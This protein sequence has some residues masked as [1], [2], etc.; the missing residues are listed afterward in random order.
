V[1]YAATGRAGTVTG[2]GMLRST[3][4]GQSWQP[5]GEGIAAL[6]AVWSIAVEPRAPHRVFAVTF[7][8]GLYVSEDHGLTW[9]MVTP[10]L[11]SE[12]ILYT[13]EIPPILYAATGGGLLRSTDG[14][15]SWSRAAGV[16]GQV[17]VYSLATVRDGE[18]VI[19]YAGTTGGYVESDAAAAL[20]QVDAEGTL[21]N[22]G[23]YRYTT[24]RRW[25]VYLPLIMRQQ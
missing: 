21:V 13:E 8:N 10:W 19:L 17:P 6:D 2:S 23:V 18:R 14:G 25:W 24:L 22:A 4:G 3:D 16:L 12:E 5:T 9:A 15:Y 1:V 7:D 11:V 20:S